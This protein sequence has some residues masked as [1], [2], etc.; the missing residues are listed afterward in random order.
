MIISIDESSPEER[1]PKPVCGNDGNVYSS[2][3]A[4]KKAS[5]EQNRSIEKQDWDLCVDKQSLCPDKV[6][7]HFIMN[8]SY[9][10]QFI[11]IF[12]LPPLDFPLFH[13]VSIFMILFVVMTMSSI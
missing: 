6:S 4:M 7:V 10:E 8:S 2:L 3:C 13:S 1:F 12:N 11:L 5:C 9:D